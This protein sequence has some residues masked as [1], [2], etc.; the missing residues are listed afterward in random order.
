MTTQQMV[1]RFIEISQSKTDED[2][3]NFITFIPAD[4]DLYRSETMPLLPTSPYHLDKFDMLNGIS[5]FEVKK[6]TFDKIVDTIQRLYG[7]CFEIIGV[8]LD[9]ATMKMLRK[10]LDKAKINYIWH[11]KYTKNGVFDKIHCDCKKIQFD[12]K[13]IELQIKIKELMQE[14]N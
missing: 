2:T 4:I 11:E 5:W 1:T 6:V 7:D 3:C 9:M 13:K 12:L 8:G 10:Q 14:F